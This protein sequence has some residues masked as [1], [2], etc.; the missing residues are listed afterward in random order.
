M[1]IQNP[2]RTGVA[3]ELSN[4]PRGLLARLFRQILQDRNISE[5]DFGGMINKYILENRQAIEDD[6]AEWDLVSARGNFIKELAGESM[7][8][9]VFLKGL[10]MLGVEDLKLSAEL[11]GGGQRTV[12]SVAL[13]V[14]HAEFASSPQTQLP[15]PPSSFQR[16]FGRPW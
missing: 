13:D 14:A 16:T 6:P 9:K 8:L 15:S 5:A 1:D 4:D 3:T 12:H 2:T 11:I 7:S 10:K